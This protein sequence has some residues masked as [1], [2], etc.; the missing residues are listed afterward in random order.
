MQV[1]VPVTLL[2]IIG[3]FAWYQD[4]ELGASKRRIPPSEVELADSRLTD[5][6]RSAHENP[7]EY[8]LRMIKPPRSINADRRVQAL[9][10]FTAVIRAFS[11]CVFL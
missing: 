4:R 10:L 9:S 6:G 8:P 11:L 7:A 3:F 1:A 5:L 2:I